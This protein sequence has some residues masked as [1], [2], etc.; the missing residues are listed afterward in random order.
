MAPIF[1]CFLVTFSFP[2]SSG[3]ISKTQIMILQVE[4]GIPPS[5]IPRWKSEF[6]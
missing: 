5:S 6:C 2:L 4:L 1:S 3:A